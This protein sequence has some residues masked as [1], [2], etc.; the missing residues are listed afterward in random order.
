MS[1]LYSQLHRNIQI[2]F[3]AADIEI[4]SPV[5]HAGVTAI[6]RRSPMRRR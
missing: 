2:Q 1:D 5:Y 3:A 4:A 6:P